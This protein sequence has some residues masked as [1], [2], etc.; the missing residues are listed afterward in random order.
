MTLAS[1]AISAVLFWITNDWRPKLIFSFQSFKSLYNFGY[2]LFLQD[3][4]DVIFRNIYYPIIGKAFTATE[5][6]Y[7]T[8][9]NRF[10]EIFVRGASYA[11]SKVVF[12]A[13]SSIQDQKRRLFN[14]YLRM[15][16]SLVFLMFPLMAILILTVKPFVAFFLT[17]KWLPAV[18]FI[19]LMFIDGFFFPLFW[20]NQTLFNAI[21]RSDITLKIDITKKILTLGSIFITIR[22]GIKGLIIGWLLSSFIAFIVSS[23][24]V[25]KRF[26]I[27]LV[28]QISNIFPVILITFLCFLVGKLGLEQIINNNLLLIIAQVFTISIMYL[29]LSNLFRIR[30]YRDFFELV[31]EYIP[32]KLR[33]FF[34]Y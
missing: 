11:Y 32:V 34:I 29:V 10:Y 27:N 6:G 9:S 22:F 18:P 23:A 13:F 8:N 17:E 26:Q 2:K 5:L 30:A 19:I 15:Y 33:K 4:S 16:K 20:L 3:M 24:V 21:G 31:R 7:Y 14:N 12:P 1:G 28:N 25:T